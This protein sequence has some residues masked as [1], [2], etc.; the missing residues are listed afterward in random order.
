MYNHTDK[1]I[2]VKHKTY[3]T[4]EV[5]KDR[6]GRMIY[7]PLKSINKPESSLGAIVRASKIYKYANHSLEATTDDELTEVEYPACKRCNKKVSFPDTKIKVDIEIIERN[8][9]RNRALDKEHRIYNACMRKQELLQ[10]KN[11][12]IKLDIEQQINVF[13]M[14]E[15]ATRIERPQDEEI[16][17]DWETKA[18]EIRSEL[19]RSVSKSSQKGWPSVG[20]PM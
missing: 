12:E 13:D 8:G 2:R 11:E 17:E 16:Q 9:S 19:K 7:T 14:T 15:Q 3:V 6:N 18:E 20:K 1:Y 4:V 5:F 10:L